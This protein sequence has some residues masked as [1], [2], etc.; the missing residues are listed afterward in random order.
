M[1]ASGVAKG[2]FHCKTAV[3]LVGLFKSKKILEMV[4]LNRFVFPLQPET[5][6]I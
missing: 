4:S 5:A 2:L 6:E 1:E 3:P